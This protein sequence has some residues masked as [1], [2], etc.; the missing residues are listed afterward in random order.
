MEKDPES[1]NV[2]TICISMRCSWQLRSPTCTTAQRIRR[3]FPRASRAERQI[4][5]QDFAGFSS[6][7]MEKRRPVPKKVMRLQVQDV[8]CVFNLFQL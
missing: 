3:Q 4:D 1:H 7:K 5:A 2:Q 6:V 8:S